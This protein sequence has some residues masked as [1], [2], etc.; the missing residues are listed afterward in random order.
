[1]YTQFEKRAGATSC[2]ILRGRIRRKNTS[3][4]DVEWRRGLMD[5]EDDGR[6]G[7]F[8]GLSTEKTE[9]RHG[10]NFTGD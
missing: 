7:Y 1:M 9:I 8:T 2:G 3:V 5:E 10:D 4:E 6:R